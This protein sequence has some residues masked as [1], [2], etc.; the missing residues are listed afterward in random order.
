MR[1]TGIK[2][3]TAIKVL[4][5]IGWADDEYIAARQLLLSDHIIQGSGLSNMAIEKYLK[6][7]FVLLGLDIPKGFKGHDISS[8]YS[9]IKDKGIKRSINEEYLALLFKAYR[10][11]YMDDLEV[12]FNI[13]LSK[14]K[15]I[16][17][18]DHTV[19]EIRKGFDFKKSNKD[20]VTRIDELKKE[21]NNV[22]LDKNCYFG[23]YNRKEFFKEDCVLHELRVLEGNQILEV[24]YITNGIDD[25][26]EFDSEGLKPNNK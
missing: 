8:L 14:T 6:S 19:Y 10:L 16:A 23:D 2:G 1:S 9:S 15:L 18:L 3:N 13:V 25:D 26:N 21:N 20:I 24:R 5:W 7:L 22:L 17:E 12:G 4:Q 11:R